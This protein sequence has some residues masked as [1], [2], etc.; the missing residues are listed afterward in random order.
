MNTTIL[1]LA[2]A[3]ALLCAT[4]G[5]MAGANSGIIH[6]VG[7]IV[8]PPCL[9]SNAEAGRINIQCERR[10]AFDVSFQRIGPDASG[11]KTT[12]TMTRDGKPLDNKEASAYRMALQGGT[13]LGL[14]VKKTAGAADPRPVLMTISYM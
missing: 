5:A 11:S 13:Q 2:A 7:N 12:V 1:K 8:E 14:S 3:S 10:S 4:S 9:T 6:F